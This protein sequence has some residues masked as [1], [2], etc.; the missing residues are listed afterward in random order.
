VTYNKRDER[1]AAQRWIKNENKRV[2]NG[3]SYKDEE[4]AARASDTLARKLIAN[5]E[6]YHKLNFPDDN[7]EVHPEK[8]NN[9]FGV[10][11][12]QRYGKWCAQRWSKKEK[13][14]VFN[15]T[16]KD[17]ETAA[18][19]SDTLVSALIAIGE[20][21]HKLNFPDDATGFF[22]KVLKK[23]TNNFG[24]YYNKSQERWRAERRSKHEKKNVYNGTTYKD[25]ETAAHAS[26]TLARKLM[27]N[28]E[29]DH[30]LNFPD[31]YTEVYSDQKTNYFG[32]SY[33]KLRAMWDAYRHSKNEKRTAHNGT[34]KDE[35]TAAHASDTLARKLIANGEKGHKLNFP[36]EDIEVSTEEETSR[37]QKRKRR[38]NLGNSQE[39]KSHQI[40]KK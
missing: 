35:E 22:P 16:Y 39:S 32:V 38:N 23:K 3:E 27:A 15:G 7:T 40:S 36:D 21:G 5:G 25:E 33:N 24:V 20:K 9:Y 18:R 19:A 4:T 17:E 13:N 12:R 14:H 26:D 11:Y 34:Y 37:K 8:K 1:W 2:Y 30:K 10:Y 6:K 29:K 31:D 28:S